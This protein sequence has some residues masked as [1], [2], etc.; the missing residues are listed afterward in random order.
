MDSCLRS[1]ALSEMYLSLTF[2]LS[3]T[4]VVKVEMSSTFPTVPVKLSK[5]HILTETASLAAKLTKI[6]ECREYS[7]IWQES[8]NQSE[9]SPREEG[10]GRWDGRFV[11]R[12]GLLLIDMRTLKGAECCEIAKGDWH[13]SSEGVCT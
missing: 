9:L 4:A 10:G 1:P 6:W 2:Q 3:Q 12:L 8:G 7:A 5:Y 11:N 13:W